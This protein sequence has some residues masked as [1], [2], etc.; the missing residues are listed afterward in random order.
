MAYFAVAAKLRTRGVGPDVLTFSVKAPDA[1]TAA[2]I[3]R[4]SPRVG[5]TYKDPI[6]SVRI[7]DQTEYRKLWKELRRDVSIQQNFESILKMKVGF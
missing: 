2:G 5:D 3:V 7:I 1:E 4:S 6:L